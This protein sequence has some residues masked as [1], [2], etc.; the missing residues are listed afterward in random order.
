MDGE[1]RDVLDFSQSV[2]LAIVGY[3]H[4]IVFNNFVNISAH[5]SN[6]CAGI[7][8]FRAKWKA[9]DRKSNVS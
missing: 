8:G 3:T 5:L 9:G 1:Y 6:K 4:L 2:C 7:Y